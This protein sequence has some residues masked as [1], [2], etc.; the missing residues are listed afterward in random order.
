MAE[1]DSFS[2]SF[3]SCEINSNIS[4]IHTMTATFAVMC[5]LSAVNSF[6][7]SAGLITPFFIH[8]TFS[9]Y[10]TIYDSFRV[11]IVLILIRY[12]DIK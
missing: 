6:T 9:E 3:E 11:F 4:I 2:L 10:R 12:M 8:N 1:H 7:T 5:Y